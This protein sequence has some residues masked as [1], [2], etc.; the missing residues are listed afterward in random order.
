MRAGCNQS[1]V[2][3][4]AAEARQ[5]RLALADAVSWMSA[6]A[7]RLAAPYGCHPPSPARR[8]RQSG[9]ARH[10]SSLRWCRWRRSRRA[11]GGS[12]RCRSPA[13][14]N[15]AVGRRTS[16]A[17][18]WEGGYYRRH[19]VGAVCTRHPR[20]LARSGRRW[21]WSSTSAEATPTQGSPR[22]S[23]GGAPWAHWTSLARLRAW[24]RGKR[25]QAAWRSR[26]V[27]LA[28]PGA[29]FEARD[30]SGARGSA[31]GARRARESAGGARWARGSAGGARRVRGRPRARYPP[32]VAV[33][34][35]PLGRPCAAHGPT[36][37]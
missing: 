15:A 1:L 32:G 37:S 21:W 9:R 12:R 4:S 26:A 6:S 23:A 28:R 3:T 11:V 7:G 2:A 34:T 22:A 29:A 27:G 25:T 36:T 8:R 14:T 35:P 20:S 24:A 31:G 10:R 16:A 33:P 17:A 30:C 5:V 13:V 18:R 19:S